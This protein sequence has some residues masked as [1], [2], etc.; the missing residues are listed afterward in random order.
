MNA[1][2]VPVDQKRI[3]VQT[4]ATQITT[5]ATNVNA[6]VLKAPNDISGGALC[7][8]GNSLVTNATGLP[9]FDY[10]GGGQISNSQPPFFLLTNSPSDWYLVSNI[11]NVQMHVLFLKYSGA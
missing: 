10:N 2:F 1:G 11:N 5:L 6:I 9:L 3:L 7:Y 4:V 8:V